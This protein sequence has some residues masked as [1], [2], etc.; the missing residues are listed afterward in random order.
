[1]TRHDGFLN[2]R[3]AAKHVGYEPVVDAHG[4]PLPTLHDPQ[5]ACFYQW[6][7]R[8]HVPKHWRGRTLLFKAEEL[9]AAIGKSTEARQSRCEQMAELG[10]RFGRGEAVDVDALV[11]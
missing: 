11:N 8:N 5:M 10:R 6:V 1:M 3:A 2:S 9:D 7:K 4:K